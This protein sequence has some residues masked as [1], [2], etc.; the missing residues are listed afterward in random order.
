MSKV[1]IGAIVVVVAAIA[2][3]GFVL[4]QAKPAS[5]N[6]ASDK[7]ENALEG[8]NGDGKSSLRELMALANNQRCTFSDTETGSSGEIFVSGGK[9][10]GDFEVTA[11]GQTISSHMISDTENLYMWTDGLDTGLKMSIIEAGEPED[12]MSGETQSVDLNQKV[13]YECTGWNVDN[14]KFD[15]PDIEFN[16]FSAMF[17][18]N[19]EESTESGSGDTNTCGICD[20]LPEESQAQCRSAL[21][22]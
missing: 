7:V 2:V 5:N 22:C 20:S 17:N 6:M 16:D 21:G 13:D 15:L 4:T 19:M 8:S 12:N 11:E 1:L 18:M 10:R 14:S 9:V 3:I